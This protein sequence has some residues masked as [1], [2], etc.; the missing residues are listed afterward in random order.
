MQAEFYGRSDETL[1]DRF[2]AT[3]TN[4]TFLFCRSYMDYHADRFADAS[5][6]VRDA[7]GRVCALLPANRD[8]DRLVS[9]GGLTYGGFVVDGSMRV[10]T[11]LEVFDASRGLLV[12]E[13]ITE[14][15]YKPVPHIY[16]IEP[17][18]ADLYALFRCDAALIRRDVG[19]CACPAQLGEWPERVASSLRKAGSAGLHVTESRDF[20][21]FWPLLEE[22]LAA[23]HGACPVHSLLE[24][25]LL[26]SRFPREIRLFVVHRAG[27]IEAGAVIYET[28]TVA[29][30]QYAASTEEGRKAG[31]PALL[32]TELIRKQFGQKRWFD[33]G[34]SVEMGGRV[35]ND[36][37]QRFKEGFGLRGV[38][39]DHYSVPLT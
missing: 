39:A 17:C 15:I 26:G 27:R 34:T 29:H 21:E 14:W 24:M 18:E 30:V 8:G 25:E 23:R 32:V 5:V 38:V 11:M 35:M 1:W 7:K 13:G 16:H 9:H 33:Y 10:A 4:G 12:A 19:A 3:S 31:A 20:L 36:G 22:N 37:L 6:V 28:K 2:V